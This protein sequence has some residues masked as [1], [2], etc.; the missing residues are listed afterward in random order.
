[1]KNQDQPRKT[2]TEKEAAQY[3]GMSV[4]FLR[5]SRMTAGHSTRT[6]GPSYVKAGRS[7]RYL[8]SDLDAWL[9]ENRVVI[10]KAG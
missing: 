7:V 6:P 10:S 3:I 8:I 1:M 9:E 4:P 2:L 5:Q